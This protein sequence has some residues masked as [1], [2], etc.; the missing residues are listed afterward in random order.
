MV[1]TRLEGAHIGGTVARGA[2]QPSS[3]TVEPRQTWQWT[4]QSTTAARWPAWW[5]TSHILPKH[6]Q[7]NVGTVSS[8]KLTLLLAIAAPSPA[9]QSLRQSCLQPAPMLIR[10]TA[11]FCIIN[12][13]IHQLFKQLMDQV[14]SVFLCC[15][16][17]WLGFWHL[18]MLWMI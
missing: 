7:M 10:W 16:Q 17:K 3:S 13:F 4:G 5:K 15:L 6:Y 14:Y 1:K 11:F 9:P 18:L 8:N 12:M 2:R